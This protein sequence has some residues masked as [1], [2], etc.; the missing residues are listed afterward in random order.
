MSRRHRHSES[1]FGPDA[2]DSDEFEEEG[3]FADRDEEDEDEEDEEEE[4][5]REETEEQ[6]AIQLEKAKNLKAVFVVR[7]NVAFDGSLVNDC[8]LPGKA[9]S[10]QIWT[11]FLR[12][13]HLISMKG[14]FSDAKTTLLG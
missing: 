5:V 6:A 10:F 1:S 11:F 13:Y 2:N 14:E 4:A 9:V 7:T 3:D 8:P 12:D